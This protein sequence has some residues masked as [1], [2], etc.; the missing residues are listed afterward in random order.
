MITTRSGKSIT[1]MALLG[2]SFHP[3]LASLGVEQIQVVQES[4]DE[5]IVKLVVAGEQTQENM[6]KLSLEII[7]R[8]KH[9]IGDEMDITVQFVAEIVPTIRGKRRFII[10]K[11][12]QLGKRG[13]GQSL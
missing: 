4:F 5:I 10:S 2:P 1:G 6:D 12:S 3:I 9:I 13:S 7:R 8:Y 11:L